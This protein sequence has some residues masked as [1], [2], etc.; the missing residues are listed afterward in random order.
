[1]TALDNSSHGNPSRRRTTVIIAVVLASA[2]ACGAG[3]VWWNAS[4]ASTPST[5][6]AAPQTTPVTSSP[7][8][9]SIR[10]P[11]TIGFGGSR[12][13][14]AGVDGAL[15]A[16]PAPDTVVS[17]GRELYRVANAP[18]VLFRGALPAW[19]DFSRGMSDGPDVRQLEQNLTDMGFGRNLTVDERFTAVTEM[20]LKA[21][22]KSVGLPQDGI[23]PLGRIVFSATDVR[24]G[25]HKATVGDH[26]TPGTPIYTR[27]SPDPVLTAQLPVSQ[28]GAV[29]VGAK[30]EI[31]L[32]GGGTSTG[33]VS[34]VGRAVEKDVE[35]KKQ[36]LI[37]LT[38][39][40]DD[41]A[42]VA[43][44]APL[45]AQLTITTPGEEDVLQ[46]PVGA[47]LAI[48]PGAFAV[49]VYSGGK[50]RTVPVSTG[51]FANGMVEVTDGK[52]SAGDDVVVPG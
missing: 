40:P 8:S 47:L 41:P 11:G 23:V 10:T 27:S 5:A 38:V 26:V 2:L 44:L 28:Q 14:T 49:E 29:A 51:R 46:V 17:A 42:A 9:S 33:T 24:V 31:A 45:T 32:P 35:G 39:K 22:Q 37:P 6:A 48:K 7:L 16:L 34:T 52:L 13:L 36:L 4:Q 19:R 15:T 18:V 30:V 3:F 50:T 20:N 21:W 1:M 43:A 12:D 25:A